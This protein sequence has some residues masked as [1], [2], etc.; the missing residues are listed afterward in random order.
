MEKRFSILDRPLLAKITLNWEVICW[1]TIVLVAIA[2]RFWDLGS[3]AQHHD[4]SMHSFYSWELY[5]GAGFIHNPLLHGPFLYHA[6]AVIYFLFGASDYTS[7]VAAALF[8]VGIVIA[9]YF[10]R[11]WLGRYGA[12]AAAGMFAI[13]P[14]FLYF[15]RFIRMDIFVAAF[16]SF[17]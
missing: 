4:E 8:G 2:L 6:T 11:K 3:R 1:V 17:L 14:G 16:E 10:L 13:S 15:S 12:L 9:P 7:R 5:R